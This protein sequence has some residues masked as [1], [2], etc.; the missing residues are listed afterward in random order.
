MYNGPPNKVDDGELAVVCEL[1]ID[2]NRSIGV[3]TESAAGGSSGSG[4]NE[5]PAPTENKEGRR[6][7]GFYLNELP[8]NEDDDETEDK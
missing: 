7:S 3:P 5:E 2:M 4:R 1:V 6:K 8:P